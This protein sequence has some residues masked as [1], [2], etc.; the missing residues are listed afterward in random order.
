MKKILKNTKGITLVALVI[1]III[2][3]ILAGIS[4]SALTNTGIFQ[5]AKDAKQKSENAALDQNT[6]LDE[7]EN[8]IDKYIPKA[9]SLA[10]AVKV[11]DYV[12]YT[13]D[14]LDKSALDKLKENLNTYSGAR[15]LKTYSAIGRDNLSLR[16]IDGDEK[17]G[18]VRLISATPTSNNTT[19]SAIGRDNLGWRVLDVD[20]KTGAVR[21]ISATPTD[22]TIVLYGYDGYNNAVKLLDDVCSTLYNSK[23]ATKVQNLKIEDIQDKMKTDYKKIDSNY[24]NRFTPSYKQYPSI[25]TKEKEQKI[26][27]GQNTTTGTELD[28]SEQKTFENQTESKQADT[29]DVKYTFWY[30]TMSANDFDGENKEMY[31]KLFINNGSNYPTYWMSSRCV[32]ANSVFADFF[33]RRVDSGNVSAN[34]LCFSRGYEYSYVYAFRPCITLNSNVQVTSGDGSE[35]TPFEIK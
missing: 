12:A 10:K 32:D 26:T 21:L 8:E 4:I 11:G 5:K 15:N 33:V 18:A 25:L 1:T 29:L 3:L 19:N 27:V 30:K 6:K 17:T 9:N 20:E 2:L 22:K 13:P 16:V 28:F 31:Y 23:L 7:Y 24:G 34:Y 14:K 35:S